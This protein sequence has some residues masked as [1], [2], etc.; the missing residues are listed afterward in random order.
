M[1][2]YAVRATGAVAALS[3]AV[4]GSPVLAQDNPST[5]ELADL[6][7]LAEPGDADVQNESQ[8]PDAV[9]PYLDHLRRMGQLDRTGCS[10]DRLVD[11]QIDCFELF[12]GCEPID[13]LVE[14]L[15]E[16]AAE[17]GLTEERIQTLAESRL[18]AARLYDAD[19]G[20]HLYI[21]VTVGGRAFSYGL[22]YKKRLHD[23]A[24]GFSLR[25]TTWNVGGVGTHGGDAGYI[26]QIVS[27]DLD[28]FVLEYLRVNEAACP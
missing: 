16:S 9:H 10:S 17:I 15:S 8:E 25:A 11:R 3:L 24:T 13:L 22:D 5:Q 2:R 1:S 21:N 23:P 19:G 12:N 7:A 26:T 6:R 28:R 27:E 4:L 14:N 20:T 18:R